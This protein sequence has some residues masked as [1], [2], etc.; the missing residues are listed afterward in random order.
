MKKKSIRCYLTYVSPLPG[1][2]NQP[3]YNSVRDGFSSFDFATCLNCGEL[4]VIDKENP[5]TFQKPLHDLA[6]NVKCPTCKNKLS[7]VLAKYPETIW[8][9]KDRYG[10]YMPDRVIPADNEQIIK[11]FFEIVF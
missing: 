7:E 4:F 9:G 8:L 6:G 10:S 2:Y 5:K 11:D 3:V 1:I